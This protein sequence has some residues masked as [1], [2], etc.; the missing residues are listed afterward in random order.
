MHIPADTLFALAI[1]ILVIGAGLGSF[2]SYWF[3]KRVRF[4]NHVIEIRNNLFGWETI[5]L[6]DQILFSKFAFGGTYKFMIGQEQAEVKIRYRWH[7]M[8]LKIKFVVNDQVI[9]EE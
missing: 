8:G 9:Y 4:S 1:G 6:N 2:N 7:F 3:K 5:L